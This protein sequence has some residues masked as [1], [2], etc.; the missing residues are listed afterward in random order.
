MNRALDRPHAVRTART[1]VREVR[2]RNCRPRRRLTTGSTAVL[3]P[4]TSRWNRL[5]ERS[6][7]FVAR[8]TRVFQFRFSV[9]LHQ[10]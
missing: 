5:S 1:F 3:Q 10:T 9:K 8:F 4:N 6:V 2:K 7:I